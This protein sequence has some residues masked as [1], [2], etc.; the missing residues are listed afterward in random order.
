MPYN[1][2]KDSFMAECKRECPVC[3]KTFWAGSEW[4]YKRGY[5]KN[6]RVYCSWKCKRSEEKENMTIGDKIN[7][8]IMDGLSDA[9]IKKTLGVTQHQ[10][11][12]RKE[13]RI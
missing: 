9:E 8:A 4:V 1:F 6:M 2:T 13:R 5:A 10:I 7:Q 3:G 12:Y 11:D